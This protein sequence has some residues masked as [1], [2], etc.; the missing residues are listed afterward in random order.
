MDYYRL[1]DILPVE[2]AVKMVIGPGTGLGQGFLTKSSF[3]PY[4]EVHPS[5]G[6]HSEYS[7]RSQE[8]FELL[9]FAS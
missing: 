4:Y 9:E 8:D 1:T 3:A 7:V 5:E 6:G 2:G